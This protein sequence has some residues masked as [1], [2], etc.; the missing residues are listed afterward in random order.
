[1]F[2]LPTITLGLTC[3]AFWATSACARLY[4]TSPVAS[5][6]W[7]GGQTE[8]ITWLDD[9]REPRISKMGKMDIE[10]YSSQHTHVT[11]LAKGINPEDKSYKVEVDPNW[12]SDGSD[13]HIRF[14]FSS[15]TIYTADFTMA[16]MQGTSTHK[17]NSKFLT[18][19]SS[20]TETSTSILSIP[21]G[22]VP[23]TPAVTFVL[24]DT[25]MTSH[26]AP[27]YMT[28]QP[29]AT[30]RPSTSFS[31]YAGGSQ[32]TVI[33]VEAKPTRL[34][35]SAAAAWTG[36]RLDWEKMKFRVVFILWP[37]MIGLTMAL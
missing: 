33:E 15:E 18:R 17:N 5:T 3:L 37:A 24:P 14:V 36:T 4:G 22:A 26:L 35:N 8:H 10:L 27:T 1:M 9:Q 34:A 23:Y 21:S 31:P 13:Y 28:P 2:N 25:I 20:N 12:G 19:T 11:T 29:T 16:N 7:N 30:N 32:T 6:I